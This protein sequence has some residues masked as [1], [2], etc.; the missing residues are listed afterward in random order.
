MAGNVKLEESKGKT[1][2]VQ[3]E[4]FSSPMFNIDFICSRW[5]W[6]VGEEVQCTFF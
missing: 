5:V 4:M 2:S 6:C 1:V 3:A